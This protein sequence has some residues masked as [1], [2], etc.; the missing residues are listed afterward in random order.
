M[1]LRLGMSPR[2]PFVLDSVRVA[3]A[4]AGIYILWHD[5]IALYVGHVQAS[6]QSIQ[7]LLLAHYVGELEPLGAS[8]F[9]FETAPDP[10]GRALQYKAQYRQA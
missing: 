1:R 4:E 8:H 10:A 9:T 3:P 2:Y 6:G 7:S 5:G